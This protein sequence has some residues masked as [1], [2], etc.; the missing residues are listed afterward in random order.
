M[1]RLVGVGD[2]DLGGAREWEHG[3]E[4]KE[5]GVDDGEVV[6]AGELHLRGPLNLFP[7]FG[8]TAALPIKVTVGASGFHGAGD[9]EGPAVFECDLR[10][11]LGAYRQ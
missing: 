8:G 7:G 6:G 10:S 11:E 5:E 4:R 1:Q 2:F 9:G 3:F